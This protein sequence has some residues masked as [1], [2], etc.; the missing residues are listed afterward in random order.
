MKILYLI[1]ELDPGGAERIVYDLCRYLLQDGGNDITVAALDGSGEYATRIRELGIEVVDFRA[2]G[3]FCAF[4]A[5]WRIRRFL[6]N[7]RFDIIHTHLYHA[8]IL[9]RIASCRLGI[10]V[11][12][13]CHITERRLLPWRFWLERITASLNSCEVAV[14]VAVKK[15]QRNHTGLADNYYRVIYNGIDLTLF[16]PISCSEKMTKRQA[17]GIGGSSRPVVGFLGRYDFQKGPD[18]YI[19]AVNH[20]PQEIRDGADFLCAG[21]GDME[22]QLIEASSGNV[23]FAGYSKNPQDYLQTLDICVVPSRWEGFGL[24]ALEAMACGCAVIAS[25]VDSLPEFIADNGNGL[26]F[27]KG[28]AKE[29]AGKILLLLNDQ[30]LRSEL[31]ENAVLTA[32]EFSLEIMAGEYLKLYKKITGDK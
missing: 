11:V 16:C 6:R 13:T 20:L 8:N 2:M 22:A 18:I 31:A 30:A 25:E 7:N 4:Q 5:L 9:G 32:K 26:L 3:V 24:V 12:S 29:L 28:N 27:N 23:R 21:Y 14:S 19:N 17:L 10:P 1:T 15:F